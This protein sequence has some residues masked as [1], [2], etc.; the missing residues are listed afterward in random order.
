MTSTGS[1]REVNRTRE[2]CVLHAKEPSAC[3][4]LNYYL[5]DSEVLHHCTCDRHFSS[6][7]ELTAVNSPTIDPQ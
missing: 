6:R 2:V 1:R 3:V 7:D 4:A 5:Q